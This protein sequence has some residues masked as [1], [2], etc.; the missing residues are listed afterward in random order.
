M[1]FTGDPSDLYGRAPSQKFTFPAPPGQREE[2]SFPMRRLEEA[3][4]YLEAIF[5]RSWLRYL[6]YVK[7]ESPATL[8]MIRFSVMTPTHFPAR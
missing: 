2:L 6:M 5:D 1:P 4:G 7:V 3:Q 8:R